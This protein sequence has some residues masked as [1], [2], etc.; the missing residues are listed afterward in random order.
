MTRQT[1]DWVTLGFT[2]EEVTGAWQHW[3][4]ALEFHA[5]FEA[6]GLP[7]SFGVLEGA[8]R[9]P[10]MIYWFVS[11]DAI[12][13]L[14]RHDVAWHRFFVCARARPPRGC[15]PALCGVGHPHT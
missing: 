2:A 12:A 8:G 6:E 7:P 14:E 10:H 9:G 13:V 11:R 3:R 1:A 15:R 5:A 4:L